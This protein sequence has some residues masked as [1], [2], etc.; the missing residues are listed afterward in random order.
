[1][2]LLPLLFLMLLSWPVS[3][4]AAPEWGPWGTTDAKPAVPAAAHDTSPLD[5]GVR[6]FQNYISPVDGPR[7]PMYPTCS[8]YARQALAKHGPWLGTMLTVDR[9]IHEN[10]PQEWQHVIRVGDHD[11]YHDPLSNNDFWLDAP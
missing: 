6:F 5:W 1:M 2:R 3:A 4:P 7:C 10:E 9:L 8:A 11:R